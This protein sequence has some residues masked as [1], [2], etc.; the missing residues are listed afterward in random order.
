MEN[1]ISRIYVQ[2]DSKI[3]L[4]RQRFDQEGSWGGGGQQADSGLGHAGFEIFISHLSGESQLGICPVDVEWECTSD[5]QWDW[6]RH[7]ETGVLGLSSHLQAQEPGYQTA[8]RGR[9]RRSSGGRRELG[10]AQ[11]LGC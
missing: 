4:P 2:D 5:F 6:R 1:R 3:S 7:V 10:S 9:P 8:Q 11:W